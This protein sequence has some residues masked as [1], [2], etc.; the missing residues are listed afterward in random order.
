MRRKAA[1]SS[2]DRSS[3]RSAP[4]SRS[5]PP[6][7]RGRSRSTSS[8]ATSPAPTPSIRGFTVWPQGPS[9]CAGEGGTSVET[10]W[11][12]PFEARKRIRDPFDASDEELEHHF[13][14][15]LREVVRSQMMSDVPLG[16]FLSGGIDSS[17]VVSMMAAEA[18]RRVQTFSIGVGDARFDE[19]QHARRVAEHL[20]TE[21]VEHIVS[22]DDAMSVVPMLPTYYDEPFSDS[23]QIPTFLVSRMWRDPG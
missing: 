9:L 4:V 23:S 14:G 20:G 18:G 13:D 21:H 19:S 11:S 5:A 6:S 16:A 7:I 2:G 1:R 8:S 3:R 10:Y 22:A 17:L 15:L 12:L